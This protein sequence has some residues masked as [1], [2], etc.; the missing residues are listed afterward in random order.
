MTNICRGLSLY[1]FLSGDN[2]LI[3]AI[4]SDLSGCPPGSRWAGKTGMRGSRTITSNGLKNVFLFD[5]QNIFSRYEGG[6]R[7]HCLEL[8]NR[9][10]KVCLVS[11]SLKTNFKLI[12]PFSGSEME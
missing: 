1:N 3:S 2:V 9:D 5:H 12:F 11:K 8:W 6:E 4:V 10:G 7:E